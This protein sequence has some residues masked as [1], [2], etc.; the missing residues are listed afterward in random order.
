[1][2]DK[3]RNLTPEECV[4]ARRASMR[5]CFLF[6]ILALVTIAILILRRQIT[7]IDWLYDYYITEEVY[8]KLDALY[9]HLLILGFAVCVIVLI[10]VTYIHEAFFIGIMNTLCD[11]EKY[12]KAELIRCKKSLFRRFSKH[13]RMN[14]GVAYLAM[15]DYENAW[16]YYGDLVPANPYQCR[17]KALL[18]RLV[19]Y[20]HDIGDDE[21]AAVYKTCL[22]GLRDSGRSNFLVELTLDDLNIEDAIKDQRYE[23]AKNL[24]AKYIKSSRVSMYTKTVYQYY[25]GVI[26]Y[27]TK[28][29]P[30]AIFH[31]KAALE[32]GEKLP[33]AEDAKA[34][35]DDTMHIINMSF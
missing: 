16:K 33:F 7:L 17:N 31:L 22:E 32:T 11:P 26:A 13:N 2:T 28:D 8:N 35:L 30:E 25:L 27:E 5:K 21:K 24:I 29:I 12:V 34:K 6:Y 1:M 18:C 3:Y 9:W 19:G 23:E 15:K 20:F 10:V 14:I 4:K